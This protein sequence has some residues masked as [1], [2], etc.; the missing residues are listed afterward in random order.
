MKKVVD[1]S[2]WLH[3][4]MNGP[5]MEYYANFLTRNF[6]D[7][8]TPTLV[9]FEVNRR[10]R[11]VAD[12]E[13]ALACLSDLEKTHVAD[14]TSDIAC[15]AAEL[16]LKYK[17]ATADS[18]IYATADIYGLKLVTS[19]SDFKNLPGVE[20]ISSEESSSPYKP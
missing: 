3:F 9:F 19:D 15:R 18:L 6:K 7:L 10:I 2:G 16:S 1:S 14:L 8:V 17:L 5:L 4:F 20:Y 13:L 11:Q 12:D